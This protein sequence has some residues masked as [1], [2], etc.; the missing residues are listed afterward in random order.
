[1]CEDYWIDA[2]AAKSRNKGMGDADSLNVTRYR[3]GSTQT[4]KQWS[5]PPT[6]PK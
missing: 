2:S 1:L 6:P 3:D 5:T 4:S